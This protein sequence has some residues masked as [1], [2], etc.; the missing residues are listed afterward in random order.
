MQWPQNMYFYLLSTS[1]LNPHQ[2]SC[3]PWGHTGCVQW[4]RTWVGQGLLPYLF[5]QDCQI[6]QIR[7]WLRTHQMHHSLRRPR[8]DLSRMGQKSSSEQRSLSL[9]LTLSS[10]P[11]VLPLCGG[12]D[13]RCG[14]WHAVWILRQSLPLLPGRQGGFGPDRRV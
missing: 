6:K 1:D 3:N 5:C 14:W 12:P 11:W 10:Q 4:W 13:P 7:T 9:N 2:H 8:K